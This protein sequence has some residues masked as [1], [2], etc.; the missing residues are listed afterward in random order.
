[1]I[2]NVLVEHVL[3]FGP[4]AEAGKELGRSV[5]VPRRLSLT[6]P[7]S[8]VALVAKS[9]IKLDQRPK[10]VHRAYGKGDDRYA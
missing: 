6:G 7:K 5:L 1:M 2:W 4:S 10:V 9:D 8:S 3:M